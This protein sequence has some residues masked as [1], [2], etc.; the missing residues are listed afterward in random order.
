MSQSQNCTSIIQLLVC[1]TAMKFVFLKSMQH[2]RPL[3]INLIER[4]GSQTQVQKN[5]RLQGKRSPPDAALC[6]A[7]WTV[8]P[9]AVRPACSANPPE[10][11]HCDHPQML[12]SL[13]PAENPGFRRVYASL[14]HEVN[15]HC[16]RFSQ[17]EVSLVHAS[18]L[19][20]TSCNAGTWQKD[21]NTDCLC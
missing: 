2:H 10:P 21:D 20:A 14:F 17:A 8:L 19:H 1:L 13:G 16:S 15:C 7:A 4:Q 3:Q 12:P 11:A 9:A 6:L 18:L 5:L